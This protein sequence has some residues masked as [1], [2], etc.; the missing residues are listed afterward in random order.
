VLNTWYSNKIEF[1]ICGD[2]NVNYLENCNKRQQLN[3]L[4]QTYNLTG[5]VTFPTH[6]VNGSITAIDDIFIARTKNDIIHPLI[7]GLSGRDAQM[8]IKNIVKKEI[9][10]AFTRRDINDQNIMEFQ[11]Q[12][13]Y[14]NW[15]EIFTEDEANTSFNKFL[16]IY[17]RIFN[18]WFIKKQKH[19]NTI[20]KPWLTKGIKIS[21]NRKKEFYFKIRENNETQHKLYYK[22]YCKILYKVIKEAKKLYYKDIITKSKNKMKTTWNIIQKGT[23]KKIKEDEIKSL[24]INNIIVHNQVS[25][26]NAFN[27]YFLNVAEKITNNINE[28]K[29]EDVH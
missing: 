3:A 29:K 15:E 24:R 5:T 11:L 22:Q 26:A 10:N 17:L 20:Y 1:V 14:E 23:G 9:N 4:L 16:N 7:N 6:K 13:S 2:I 18:C 27:D 21:C 25:I 12:L 8:M 19:S 28:D